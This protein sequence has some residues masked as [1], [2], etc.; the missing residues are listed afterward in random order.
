MVTSICDAVTGQVFVDGVVQ[1]LENA[2]VQ[3]ALV[4][5]ADVHARA[6]SNGFQTLKFIDLGGV[7]GLRIRR[8]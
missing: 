6:F 5:V 4:R 7:I 1:H 8:R 2:V 3:T